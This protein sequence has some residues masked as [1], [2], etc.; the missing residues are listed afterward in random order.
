[1]ASALLILLCPQGQLSND[2]KV[3]VE[4]VLNTSD[5][6]MFLGSSPDEVLTNPAAGHGPDLAPSGTTG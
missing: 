3:M 4:P 2:A 1:M 6:N 5:I